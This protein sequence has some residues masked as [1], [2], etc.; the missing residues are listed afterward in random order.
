MFDANKCECPV[1]LDLNKFLLRN[2]CSEL[3]SELSHC[4]EFIEL[5]DTTLYVLL[6]NYKNIIILS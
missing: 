5:Q 4:V 1:Y 6:E 2:M 3:S